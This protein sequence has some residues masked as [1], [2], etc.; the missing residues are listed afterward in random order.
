LKEHW[1]IYQNGIWISELV[2][3]TNKN[4]VNIFTQETNISYIPN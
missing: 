3:F 2:H 1:A 4:F